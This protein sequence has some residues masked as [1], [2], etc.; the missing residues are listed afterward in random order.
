MLSLAVVTTVSAV[1][2][3][4][5][6]PEA[7]RPPLADGFVNRNDVDWQACLQEETVAQ[8]GMIKIAIEDMQSGEFKDHPC[9]LYKCN[10]P[11]DNP[12]FLRFIKEGKESSTTL[13]N[14][15]WPTVL[16]ENYLFSS[17]VESD[18]DNIGYG[19]RIGVASDTNDRFHFRKFFF[20]SM[21]D[22][23]AFV[24]PVAGQSSPPATYTKVDFFKAP[25]YKITVVNAHVDPTNKF[26]DHYAGNLDVLQAFATQGVGGT[27]KQ[28]VQTTTPVPAATAADA[29]DV[30]EYVKPTNP[31]LQ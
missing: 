8:T 30:V 24:A 19:F 25:Q 1:S 16:D 29:D 14:L 12:F 21:G 11:L 28:S 6:Q 20:H 3:G 5:L 4:S 10:S 9:V 18:R 13:L 26:G 17:R 22:L 2:L 15:H 31:A 23:N 7:Q 27:T